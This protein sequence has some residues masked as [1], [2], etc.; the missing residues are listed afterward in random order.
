MFNTHNQTRNCGGNFAIGP[1]Q[2]SMGQNYGHYMANMYDGYQNNPT[3]VKQYPGNVGNDHFLASS[4]DNDGGV[5]GM[6]NQAGIFNNVDNLQSQN[7][8][9]YANSGYGMAI[10]DSVAT[11]NRSFS[12]NSSANN[13]TFDQTKPTAGY[14]AGIPGKNLGYPMG[15][16]PIGSRRVSAPAGSAQRNFQQRSSAFT[17]QDMTFPGSDMNTGFTQDHQMVH[18]LTHRNYPSE[19]Y[20]MHQSNNMYSSNELPIS[21]GGNL[22]NYQKYPSS[23]SNS[24]MGIRAQKG[25][26]SMT[27]T[28]VYPGGASTAMT[29]TTSRSTIQRSFSTGRVDDRMAASGGQLLPSGG[30]GQLLPS[31]SFELNR[32]F[33]NGTEFG[34]VQM[35]ERVPLMDS[36]GQPLANQGSLD[37]MNRLSTQRLRHY[38]P[39][40]ANQGMDFSNVQGM[41]SSF[42]NTNFNPMQSTQPLNSNPSTFDTGMTNTI[43]NMSPSGTTNMNMDSM[44]L[45]NQTAN[46]GYMN[47]GFPNNENFNIPRTQRYQNKSDGYGSGLP[48][49]NGTDMIGSYDPNINH[50]SMGKMNSSNPM[51]FQQQATRRQLARTDRIFSQELEKLAKLSRNPMSEPFTASP[52]VPPIDS[53]MNPQINTFPGPTETVPSPNSFPKTAISPEFQPEPLPQPSQIPESDTFMQNTQMNRKPTKQM[54]SLPTTPFSGPSTP[55]N[56]ATTTDIPVSSSPANNT[57]VSNTFTNNDSGGL[58]SSE[59]TD[60]KVDAE[61]RQNKHL[62]R[63]T[64]HTMKDKQSDS[65]NQQGDY[66]SHGNAEGNTEGSSQNCIAALSA[67]CRNMIAVMDSSM[68]KQKTPTQGQVSSSLPSFET[69]TT[70]N[71]PTPSYPSNQIGMTQNSMANNNANMNSFNNNQFNMNTDYS[72]GGTNHYMGVDFQMQYHDFLEQSLPMQMTHKR[73]DEKPKRT[74]RRKV[75]EDMSDQISNTTGQK[76]RRS[77]KKSQNPPSVDSIGTPQST[78]NCATPALSD[79][80]L[81]ELTN[82]GTC[83]TPMQSMSFGSLNSHTPSPN[84]VNSKPS[85]CQDGL[86]GNFDNFESVFS[87]DTTAQSLPQESDD[88]TNCGLNVNTSLNSSKPSTPNR[89]SSNYSNASLPIVSPK[90]GSHFNSQPNS[91]P[92]STSSEF[93]VSQV[94][95]ENVMQEAGKDSAHPL[96]ILQQQI[97]IQRQ[98]FNLGDT[99]SIGKDSSTVTTSSCN[100]INRSSDISVDALITDKNSAWY[101]TNDSKKDEVLLPWEDSKKAPSTIPTKVEQVDRRTQHKLSEQKRR[102]TIKNSFENLKKVVPDCQNLADQNQQSVLLKAQTFIVDMIDKQH[103]QKLKADNFECLKSKNRQLEQNITRIQQEYEILSNMD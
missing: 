97:Q 26:Y 29:R 58:Q 33:M 92:T 88:G 54:Q 68:P 32:G 55:S 47:S 98:Q 95:A 62:Q 27:R 28:G 1:D 84:C 11:Q 86:S 35:K 78:D 19:Q 57:P 80:F 8:S 89:P 9:S 46:S 70:T 17:Q 76:R 73:P 30:S 23:Y 4:T 13:D 44:G 99:R 37:Q 69:L 102:E 85:P 87:P 3:H 50:M 100:N 74:R 67:A 51:Q 81:D 49:M 103:R 59:F 36:M 38:G 79:N 61:K 71:N 18:S 41:D 83:N 94:P 75:S 53:T 60:T 2:S 21:S 66:I 20:G 96:E 34:N 91:L 16:G 65:K 40:P 90:S 72:F 15:S 31:A 7:Y 82:T 56:Q 14:G 42:P 93:N 25:N 48:N 10:P 63:L 24:S 12:I 45:V 64:S 5:S 22:Q 52:I 101:M 39:P 43:Q 6:N 77:T